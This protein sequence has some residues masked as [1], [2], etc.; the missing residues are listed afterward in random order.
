MNK[1]SNKNLI[2]IQYTHE[3]IDKSKFM[4]IKIFMYFLE[5]L[6]ILYTLNDILGIFKI[7]ALNDKFNIFH[8]I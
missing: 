8:K 4:M 2:I 5:T 3:F 1:K 7:N 6:I